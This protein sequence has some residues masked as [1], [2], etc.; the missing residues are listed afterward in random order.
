MHDKRLRKLKTMRKEMDGVTLAGTPG[1]PVALL[2]W[3]SSFGAVREA[4][5]RLEQENTPARVV[6]LSELWPFP[7][8]PVSRA[9]EGAQKIIGVEGNAV[10]QLNRLLRQETGLAADHL[11]LRYDGRPFTPEYLLR[12]LQGWI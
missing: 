2:C 8:E 1:A 10:G 6:H 12:G 5:E 9:L 3:G 4:A 11:V 7:K